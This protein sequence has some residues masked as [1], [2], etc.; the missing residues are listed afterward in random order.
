V[1]DCLRPVPS[2]PLVQSMSMAHLRRLVPT[3][4]NNWC[5]DLGNAASFPLSNCL[6]GHKKW[7]EVRPLHVF[8]WELG[9]PNPR[10][11]HHFL[12]KIAMGHTL[13]PFLDYLHPASTAKL[14]FWFQFWVLV[15]FGNLT[16]GRIGIFV[17][18]RFSQD[19]PESPLRQG[20]GSCLAKDHL[21][22]GGQWQVCLKI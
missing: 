19:A 10:V 12:C 17:Q 1:A 15:T 11:Y 20:F 7:S 2:N 14:W 6:G 16:L 22:R 13:T 9:P 18:W 8:V 21:A 5:L 4:C 3:N